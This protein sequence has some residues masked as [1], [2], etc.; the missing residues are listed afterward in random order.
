MQ[1]Y[2]TLIFVALRCSWQA[3]LPHWWCIWSPVL[4]TSGFS[5]ELDIK[6]FAHASLTQNLIAPSRD[7]KI[8]AFPSYLSASVLRM[9]IEKGCQKCWE[10]GF[11]LLLSSLSLSQSQPKILCHNIL[12][13]MTFSL[14]TKLRFMWRRLEQKI[15]TGLE[16]AQALL[17]LALKCGAYPFCAPTGYHDY[18]AISDALV[19]DHDIP[20]CCLF[21]EKGR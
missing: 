12:A 6:S 8:V 11:S 3:T 10:P 19:L 7:S 13:A 9:A 18:L 4:R 21:P 1:K 15:L 17:V 16:L 5:P 14:F 2:S 20:L